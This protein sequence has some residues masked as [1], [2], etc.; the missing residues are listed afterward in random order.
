[1]QGSQEERVEE[2]VIDHK[3]RLRS[4]NTIIVIWLLL[5]CRTPRNGEEK[6]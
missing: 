1:M 6:I 3:Y 5:I 4:R 2:F